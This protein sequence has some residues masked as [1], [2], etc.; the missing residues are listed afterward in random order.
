[1]TSVSGACAA[2]VAGAGWARAV[3][4]ATTTAASVNSGERARITMINQ[5]TTLAGA[6]SRVMCRRG[7]GARRADDL[8]ELG[9]RQAAA[10]H[11]SSI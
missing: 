6:T 5:P 1:M 4:V 3:C 8:C 2:L 9:D 10:D 11:P 7:R